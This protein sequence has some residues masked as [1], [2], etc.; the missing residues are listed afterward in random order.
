MKSTFLLLFTIMWIGHVHAQSTS[1]EVVA[2]AGDTFQGNNVRIEW[3]LG[4]L[5]IT[6]VQN[7]SQQI[8][9]GFHQPYYTITSVDELPKNIG[10]ISVFPNPTS[11]VIKMRLNFSQHQKVQ[12]RL[13]DTQGHI[14]LTK[15]NFGQIINNHADISDLPS[16]TYFLNFSINNQYTQTFKIQKI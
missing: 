8:T 15:E 11:E 12:I 16:G 9:Q 2:S 3:T 7:A 1:P 6:T 10:Q 14:L 13:T 5:A 4:E